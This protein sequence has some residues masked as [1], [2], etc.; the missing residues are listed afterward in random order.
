MKEKKTEVAI[1]EETNL[2]EVG[3]G[4][5]TFLN[6]KAD[7]FYESGFLPV[8]IIKETAMFAVVGQETAKN[9]P[10]IIAV[11][12]FAEQTRSL[13]S[14]GTDAEQKLIET[15]CGS[16]PMCSSRNNYGRK[17]ALI[18]VIEGDTPDIVKNAVKPP[19]DAGFECN[20]C[21]Y[22]EFGSVPNGAGKLC[23]EQR[24]FLLWVP[25]S[26]ITSILSISPSSLRN[27]RNFRAGLEDKHFSSVITKISLTTMERGRNKWAVANFVPVGKVTPELVAPLGRV[28]MYGGFPTQEY[29]AMEAEFLGTTLDKDQDY[30][31]NGTSSSSGSQADEF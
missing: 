9:F 21:R 8:K 20:V 24:R 6:Q 15:W 3:T 30:N 1:V 14:F 25:E 19:L 2:A 23:K 5:M 18:E 12:L 29:R 7:E 10:E 27:W 4:V 28:I 11:I 16:R 13:W 22:N 31:T 26:S 17:G